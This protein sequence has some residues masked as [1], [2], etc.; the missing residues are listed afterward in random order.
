M[1]R[2]GPNK[3]TSEVDGADS[4]TSKEA[5]PSAFGI[6]RCLQ[7]PMR[8]LPRSPG[9][10]QGPDRRTNENVARRDPARRTSAQPGHHSR[11]NSP[12]NSWAP[13]SDPVSGS[14]V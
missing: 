11:L 7:L 6:I 14:D 13:W 1:K 3:G 12:Q 2:S 4:A 5:T 9:H 10:G 8:R